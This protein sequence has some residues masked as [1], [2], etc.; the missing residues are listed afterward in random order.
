MYKTIKKYTNSAAQD[1]CCL[2]WILTSLFLPDEARQGP[3]NTA[4]KQPTVFRF[5]FYSV[6]TLG[7]YKNQLLTI[8][9]YNQLNKM[10]QSIVCFTDFIKKIQHFKHKNTYVK[11]L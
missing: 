5:I 10:V 3:Y 6:I 9:I 2:W 1:H 8:F 7:L 11:N 4:T